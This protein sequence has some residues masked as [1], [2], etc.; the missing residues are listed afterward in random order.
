MDYDINPFQEVYVADSVDD[1]GFAK[2]FSKVPLL[3]AIHPVFQESNVV[4]TGTQGCGKSMILRLLVPQVRIGFSHAGEPFPVP[5]SLSDFF[6]AGVNL[7]KSAI[8]DVAQVT[9]GQG[10]DYDL[11]QLPYYFG[12]FFNWWILK[13]LLD[14]LNIVQK[15]PLVFG[16]MVNLANEQDF[17]AELTKQDCWFGALDG[18]HLLKDVIERIQKRVATYRKWVSFNER[19]VG[20]PSALAET[21]TAVG[22]PIS[23]TVDCLK[24][25]GILPKK[26]RVLVRVDQ[27]EELHQL[28]HAADETSQHRKSLRLAFRW[29]L[30]RAF[31]SRD[32]AVHYRIG[33]RQYGWNEKD[34]LLVHG[35]GAQLELRRDYLLVDMDDK[36]FRRGE[37]TGSKVFSEFAAD[38]FRR[39][40]HYA[41]SLEELPSMEQASK[42]FGRSPT[43][44]ERAIYYGRS[45]SRPVRYE[46]ALAIESVEKEG[47]HWNPEWRVFLKQLYELDPLEAVLAGAWAR[48]TG[49]R[50]FKRARYQDPPPRNAPW[51]TKQWWRKE[52]LMQGVLQL[53]ARRQQRLW[54]WG[55]G[56]I[57]SLSGGNI[58][59]FLHVCHQIWDQFLKVE[60]AKPLT[61][62]SDPLDEANTTVIAK[63]IQAIGIQNASQSWLE[64]LNERPAGDLRRQFIEA[65]GTKLRIKLRDDKAMSYPG[66]NGFSIL[67]SELLVSI[68]PVSDLWQFLCDACGYGALYDREHTTKAQSGKARVK[69]YLHPV[70]SPQFQIPVA[71]Q[72]EP[73]YWTIQELLA[74]A[75]DSDLPFMFTSDGT[76]KQGAPPKKTSYPH[77]PAEKLLF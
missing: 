42:T 10:R 49:G 23:R 41:L 73:L 16:N 3:P 13:D 54:W 2:L 11:E 58:S 36:L 32:G 25:T 77:D 29:M 57:L 74:I 63:D 61:E 26:V 44:T 66:G 55:Y 75:A 27:L 59:V 4:L 40:L 51:K 69:F 67:K 48:Q 31:G 47:E 19:H 68:H 37:N 15:H 46:H 21:K 1:V 22:E 20:A 43:P 62:R 72:K 64:K 71:H 24:R 52:R 65:L 7:T 12:D 33:T 9:L 76:R 50:Q 17:I 5:E 18:C 56:D 60:R 70:L 45:K 28:G 6:S 53:A 35:S 34:V 30:N 8:C 39:R 38:A 14:N